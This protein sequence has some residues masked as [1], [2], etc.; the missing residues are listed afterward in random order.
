MVGGK[1][2]QAVKIISLL[3]VVLLQVSCSGALR[4]PADASSDL[5]NHRM[6]YQLSIQQQDKP[7][8]SGLLVLEHK[9]HELTLLGVSHAGMTLFVLQRDANGETLKKTPFAKEEYLPSQLLNALLLAQ[10]NEEYLQ[11]A[12]SKNKH[13]VVKE[14][15]RIVQNG[16]KALLHIEKIDTETYEILDAERI[17]RFQLLS[18]ELIQ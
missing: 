17:L 18:K 11:G 10:Y 6:I 2:W 5:V 15:K 4:L 3:C 13:I 7:S 1:N 12:L 8:L 16:E 9:E 14:Q